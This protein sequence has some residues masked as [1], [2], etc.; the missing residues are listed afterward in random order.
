MHTLSMQ[1]SASLEMTVI[2]KLLSAC[3]VTWQ[4]VRMQLPLEVLSVSC[5]AAALHTLRLSLNIHCDL[6]N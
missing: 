6:F 5:P 3:I 4:T 1:T 2:P